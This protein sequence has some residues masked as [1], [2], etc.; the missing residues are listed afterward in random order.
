ML[1]STWYRVMNFEVRNGVDHTD[2]LGKEKHFVSFVT[3]GEHDNPL[4][5]SRRCETGAVTI[6]ALGDHVSE[7]LGSLDLVRQV[8][9]RLR[10]QTSQL[11]P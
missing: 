6:I 7:N 10:S 8:F 9:T 2:L 1:L 3:S 11:N 5:G 4:R